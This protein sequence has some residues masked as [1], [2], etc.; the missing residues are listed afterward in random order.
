VIKTL[1]YHT[2]PELHEPCVDLPPRDAYWT[3]WADFWDT[4]RYH[5]GLGLSAPQIG[6]RWRAFMVDGLLCVNPIT[7]RKS[8]STTVEEE[9]CL[10]IPGVTVSVERPSWIWGEYTGRNGDRITWKLTGLKARVWQHEMDHLDG[11]LITDY[12]K[13]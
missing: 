8:I 10:S 5:K 4:L 13:K 12:Q 1:V 6:L 9:G 7:K 2:A 3:L 11:I